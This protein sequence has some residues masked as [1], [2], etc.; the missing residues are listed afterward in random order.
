MFNSDLPGR[1]GPDAC[2]GALQVH[3]AADGGLA[4]VRIPGGAVTAGQLRAVAA[5][6]REL[7]SGVIELTSRANLQVRG[8]PLPPAA[9]EGAER[10]PAEAPDFAARMAAAGLLPSATH[11]RV[12]NIVASPLAGRNAAS[13][14]DVRPLVAELDRALCARPGLAELPGRFLFALDDGSGDVAALEADVTL[15]PVAAGDE[16]EAAL[17]LAGA[18]PG[19][20]APSGAE[21]A[22]LLAVAEAFLAERA[23]QGSRAWRLRE[24]ADGPAR[25]AARAVQLEPRLRRS[26]A[27]PPE[28]Y[29]AETGA[30]GVVGVVGVVGQRDGRVAL[31]VLPPLGRLTPAQAEAL[32]EAAGDGAGEV[33][34]TPWRTVV[35]PDLSPADAGRW[36][37]RLAEAGLVADPASPWLGLTAC[38]GRPG[39]GKSRA[40]VHADIRAALGDPRPDADVSHDAVR[41]PSDNGRIPAHW[42]GCERRCGRPRGRVVDVVATGHGYRVEADGVS[43]A[44]PDAEQTS[45]AVAATREGL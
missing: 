27:R 41:S 16:N 1:S 10:A 12:R 14:R 39:C 42:A 23:A 13:G 44:F 18:D 8:L 11:E 19:L 37:A 7:G 31:A 29:G 35:V 40:D 38:A 9:C 3:A 4:R 36:R 15:R 21:T 17:L 25:V 28:A 6:A 24:L 34:V 45:A 30:V 43:R 33:R 32:A 2:P 5:A 20:R 26:S 22:G